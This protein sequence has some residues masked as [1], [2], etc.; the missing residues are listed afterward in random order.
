MELGRIDQL[1]G[2][3]SVTSLAFP[4]PSDGF[5]QVSGST[6]TNGW[7]LLARTTDGG[8]S[9]QTKI[10]RRRRPIWPST[11]RCT[12]GPTER[13]TH[14]HLGRA[15]CR[16]QTGTHL[17]HCGDEGQCLFTCD[18]GPGHLDAGVVPSQTGGKV[19]I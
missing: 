7:A 2:K 12:G 10:G 6:G 11:L 4:S 18:L 13:L 1:Y 9:W 14:D 8:R 16:P 3:W 19:P 17:A 5:A 15:F